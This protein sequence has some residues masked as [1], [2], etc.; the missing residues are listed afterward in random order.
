MTA[1]Q[2]GAPLPEGLVTPDLRVVEVLALLS[3]VDLARRREF[4]L[5]G[6]LGIGPLRAA[7]VYVLPGA[8]LEAALLLV[9]R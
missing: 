1:G 7:S 6:N 8:L 5:L 2:Q 4:V 3:F 9:P